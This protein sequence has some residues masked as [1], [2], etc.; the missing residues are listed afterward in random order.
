[1]SESE[2]V[3]N[4]DSFPPP[5][6]PAS[7]DE[8]ESYGSEPDDPRVAGKFED[9]YEVPDFDPANEERDMCAEEVSV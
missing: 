5:E 3:L 2:Q 6:G 4:E 9:P 7:P 8:D 1:M